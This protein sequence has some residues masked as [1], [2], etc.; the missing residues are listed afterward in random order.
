MFKKIK[1]LFYK[2]IEL[3]H[4]HTEVPD[5]LEEPLELPETIEVPWQLVARVKNTE[6]AISK[7]HEDL[8]EFFY[9]N[10]MTEKK[11]FDLISRLEDASEKEEQKIKKSFNIPEDVQYILEIP[12]TTGRPG[13][14]KKVSQDK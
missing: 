1:S 13:L 6:E 14:L 7:L 9:N 8:K 2:E 12:N 11:T 3:E 10:K 5:I 4:Q